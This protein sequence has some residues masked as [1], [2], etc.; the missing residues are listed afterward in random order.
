M[1]PSNISNL[2]TTI[3][4]LNNAGNA[5]VVAGEEAFNATGM[6][7]K[8]AIIENVKKQMERTKSVE[9]NG[10]VIASKK[11]ISD[12]ES[13][14]KK[15]NDTNMIVND[16]S[17]NIIQIQ[18]AIEDSKS[19]ENKVNVKEF[20]DILDKYKNNDFVKNTIIKVTNRVIKDIHD[21]YEKTNAVLKLVN[22]PNDDNA[23]NMLKAQEEFKNF[24]N[25]MN[26]M[27][28]NIDT[29]ITNVTDMDSAV[30]K[31]INSETDF[32]YRDLTIN[33]D[34]TKS[35]ITKFVNSIPEI[36]TINNSKNDYN[37]KNN[38]EINNMEKQIY[39]S[40]YK[41]RIKLEN[42]III[43]KCYKNIADSEL[44]AI[45]YAKEIANTPAI[46][47][48][49]DSAS[50][51]AMFGAYLIK[52]ISE[53]NIDNEAIQVNAIATHIKHYYNVIEKI[54]LLANYI[55]TSIY[56]YTL[57]D[58]TTGDE[59]ID[60]AS[61]AIK[62]AFY[63]YYYNVPNKTY[64]N[65]FV[66]L[67][68]TNETKTAEKSKKILYNINGINDYI[69]GSILNN[70]KNTLD[71]TKDANESFIKSTTAI[72]ENINNINEKLNKLKEN[73]N[74]FLLQITKAYKGG[75]IKKRIQNSNIMN[76][77]K[78]KKN[79]LNNRKLK[80]QKRIN[81]LIKSKKK[82]KQ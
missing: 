14:K 5:A 54:N 51:N 16:T 26:Q 71:K 25:D 17:N 47:N 28:T 82:N 39:V 44:N 12:T 11:L 70:V 37:F 33:R 65:P 27:M 57:N 3:N 48:K 80:K 34:N 43:A 15:V 46:K 58:V 2:I 60:K 42:L 31:A 49:I 22:A 35:M 62:E 36:I 13:I 67:P 78:T 72:N 38:I 40:I 75:T 32:N 41:I 4:E 18:S 55:N 56:H 53:S 69:K 9:T 21:I 1:I 30:K 68:V 7:D 19:L 50:K 24:T 45:A 61:E 10:M 63:F 64:S 29:T 74:E 52:Y 66:L 73:A 59:N 8:T 76:L 20:D 23:I 77:I 6:T 81:N 79:I